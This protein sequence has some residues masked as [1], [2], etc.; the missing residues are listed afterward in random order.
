MNGFSGA[1]VFAL[2]LTVGCLALG[3]NVPAV[4]TFAAC[5]VCTVNA[6]RGEQ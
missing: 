4:V 6:S 3:W 2:S 5:I 1:A